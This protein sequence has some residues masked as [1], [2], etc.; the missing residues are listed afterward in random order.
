M[1]IAKSTRKNLL[2]E[3]REKTQDATRRANFEIVVNIVWYF[4][5]TSPSSL[6]FSSLCL[7]EREER[8]CRCGSHF[9]CQNTFTNATIDRHRMVNASM[10]LLSF[11]FASAYTHTH[12]I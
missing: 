9:Q 6:F 1:Y 5:A 4:F 11:L 12:R 10:Y 3:L 7:T 8:R 2:S